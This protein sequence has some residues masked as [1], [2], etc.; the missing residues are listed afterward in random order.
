MILGSCR[1]SPI[2]RPELSKKI[3]ADAVAYRHR[4]PRSIWPFT[5]SDTQTDDAP[6]S[7]STVEENVLLER[8]NLREYPIWRIHKYRG[9]DLRPMEIQ[10]HPLSPSDC[11]QLLSTSNEER[12]RDE[13]PDGNGNFLSRR[14]ERAR[15][16]AF[17][18]KMLFHKNLDLTGEKISPADVEHATPGASEIIHADSDRVRNYVRVAQGEI[19]RTTD[20]RDSTQPD[21]SFLDDLGGLAYFLPDPE[22]D[23]NAS[24]RALTA[25]GTKTGVSGGFFSSLLSNLLG[26]Q[27]N[28]EVTSTAVQPAIEDEES[29]DTSSNESGFFGSLFGFGSSPSKETKKPIETK[30]VEPVGYYYL[31]AT[32]CSYVAIKLP[33]NVDSRLK[34]QLIAGLDPRA[35][36][37]VSNDVAPAIPFGHS[38]MPSIT[39]LSTPKILTNY[40]DEIAENNRLQ[41]IR[42]ISN[43]NLPIWE[44]A[45]FHGNDESTKDRETKNSRRINSG[46]SKL[47]QSSSNLTEASAADSS[48]PRSS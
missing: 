8:L 36:T 20:E 19:S 23:G 40:R 13:N 2:Q 31:P 14:R 11:E 43:D 34:S 27:I 22:D 4:S 17:G 16:S 25:A 24:A 35:V 39:T 10:A 29:E 3:T 26:G 38:E 5:W 33:A 47:R 18:V 9:I 37:F 45:D 32:R 12:A 30:L 21:L 7:D 41:A 28:D 46:Y 44:A 6:V 15:S 48:T 42:K 1:S